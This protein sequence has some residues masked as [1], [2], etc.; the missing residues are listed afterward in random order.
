M[1]VE[2]RDRKRRKA[3]ENGPAHVD[4]YLSTNPR[5]CTQARPVW[6][7]LEVGRYYHKYL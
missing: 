2:K 6:V 1:K 4:L 7:E 5:L 3:M